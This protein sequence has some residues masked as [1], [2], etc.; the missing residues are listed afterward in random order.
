[1]IS[2]T[3]AKQLKDSE[4]D[5]RIQGRELGVQYVLEGSVRRAGANVRITAQL[6]NVETDAHVWGERFSGTLED[7]FAIQEDLDYF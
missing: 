6:I 7:I 3:S 5:L 4:K 1:M 2:R